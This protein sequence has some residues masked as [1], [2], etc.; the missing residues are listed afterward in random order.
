MTDHARDRDFGVLSLLILLTLTSVT[1]WVRQLGL[2]D[3]LGV[4]TVRVE[5][6]ERQHGCTGFATSAG[7]GIGVGTKAPITDGRNTAAE[8]SISEGRRDLAGAERE[9]KR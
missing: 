5:I 3:R 6:L 2:R 9:V 8:R 4:L 1:S 7:Y